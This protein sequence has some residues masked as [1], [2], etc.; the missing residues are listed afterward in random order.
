[1]ISHLRGTLD[2]VSENC[3]EIDTGSLGFTVNV[4]SS[5][6]DALPPVGED[7]DLFTYLSVKEDDMSLFGFLTRDS[8]DMFKL[9][10]TVNGIGPKA[11]LSVL[12]AMSPQ[13]IRLAVLSSDAKSLSRAPGIGS[14]TAQRMIIE[15]KDK[16][17]LEDAFAHHSGGL[18]NA[19]ISRETPE[20]DEAVEALVALGYSASDALR[21]V[22]AVETDGK[23]TEAILREALKKVGR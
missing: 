14:K 11:A 18:G 13:D 4:P 8:L 3:I 15:L 22:R 10:I 16:V 5:V 9:L 21:A 6:I 20:R 2:Y 17:T 23:D 19:V 1:M 12:S 7:I